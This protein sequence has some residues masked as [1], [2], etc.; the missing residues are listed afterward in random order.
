MTRLGKTHRNRTMTEEARQAISL[1]LKQR[2]REHPHV[3]VNNGVTAKYVEKKDLVEWLD[4]GWNRGALPFTAERKASLSRSRLGTHQSE[5]TR[6][7]IR[8]KRLGGKGYTKGKIPVNNGLK[9]MYITP[10]ELAS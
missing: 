1:K 10:E 7:K 9:S 4:R 5:E 2:N 8:E 3:K 6:Q